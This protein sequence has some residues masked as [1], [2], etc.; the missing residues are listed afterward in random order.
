[1]NYKKYCFV[2]ENVKKIGVFNSNNPSLDNYFSN[3]DTL[4]L[5]NTKPDIEFDAFLDKQ[6]RAIL[7]YI[8]GDNNVPGMTDEQYFRYKLLNTIKVLF[9]EN[10][11]IGFNLKLDSNSSFVFTIIYD[12]DGNPVKN[13]ELKDKNKK[14]TLISHTYTYNFYQ[15]YK[16]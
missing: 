11:I 3:D 16:K 6:D 7:F 12:C 13:I 2:P 5:Q 8:D 15:K 14:K 9:S 1:M 10:E 4:F